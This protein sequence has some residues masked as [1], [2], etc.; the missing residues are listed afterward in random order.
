VGK[1]MG[2]I[3][4]AEHPP[5]ISFYHPRHCLGR[6]NKAPPGHCSWDAAYGIMS[7]GWQRTEEVMIPKSGFKALQIRYF[8]DCS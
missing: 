1:I 2:V 7:A 6:A 4:R 5:T 8:P 3:F